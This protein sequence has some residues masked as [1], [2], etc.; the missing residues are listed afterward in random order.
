MLQP[1]SSANKPTSL[2]QIL[3]GRSK[4]CKIRRAHN[5][6]IM[7]NSN[8]P[9][10]NQWLQF[11]SSLGKSTIIP[12]CE[13]G[14]RCSE[15]LR[16]VPCFPSPTLTPE[17]NTLCPCLIITAKLSKGAPSY[18]TY[19][20]SWACYGKRSRGM[21]NSLWTPQSFALR[22][23]TGYERKCLLQADQKGKATAPQPK[24][25]H[26]DATEALTPGCRRQLHRRPRAES[27]T[28]WW[29]VRLDRLWFKVR[30]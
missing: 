29:A 17:Q 9:T 8:A 16:V 10:W 13:R 2:S 27:S 28:L 19:W 4:L 14:Q 25:C 3:P 30:A 6:E 26:F 15:K 12:F 23:K 1:W 5:H 24:S 21:N 18:P 11:Q 7:Y 20:S 22:L